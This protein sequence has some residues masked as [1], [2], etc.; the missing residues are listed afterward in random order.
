MGGSFWRGGD[1]GLAFGRRSIVR[2]KPKK[3]G[4]NDEVKV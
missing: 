2:K 1:K 3:F 4:E